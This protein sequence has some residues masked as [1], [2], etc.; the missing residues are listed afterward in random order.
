MHVYINTSGINVTTDGAQLRKEAQIENVFL[1]AMPVG[2]IEKY[3]TYAANHAN[4]ALLAD[5]TAVLLAGGRKSLVNMLTSLP[6]TIVPP[7]GGGIKF[8]A[9]RQTALQQ[10]IGAHA[11]IALQAPNSAARFAMRRGGSAGQKVTSAA[12]TFMHIHITNSRATKKFVYVQLYSGG[13]HQGE[14]LLS[15]AGAMNTTHLAQALVNLPNW[16]D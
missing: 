8:V 15:A 10:D 4:I 6:L 1:D 12:K 2:G 3:E 16:R 11:S 5:G 7:Q 14:H 13:A 9:V